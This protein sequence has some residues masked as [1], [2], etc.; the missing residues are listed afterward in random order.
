MSFHVV[1][2]FER[3]RSD[4]FVILLSIERAA[5]I[6]CSYASIVV[7]FL[8]SPE[9]VLSGGRPHRRSSVLAPVIEEVSDHRVMSFSGGLVNEN[10]SFADSDSLVDSAHEAVDSTVANASD[11][12]VAQALLKSSE[13]ESPVVDE[14]VEYGRVSLKLIDLTMETVFEQAHLQETT[15]GRILDD[16]YSKMHRQ[17]KQF[18]A[19]VARL[20]LESG[21]SVDLDTDGAAARARAERLVPPDEH[22]DRSR[23]DLRFPDTTDE[24]AFGTLP[25]ICLSIALPG[26]SMQCA[27]RKMRIG[28]SV[29]MIGHDPVTGWPIMGDKYQEQWRPQRKFEFEI[30]LEV[31]E[32]RLRFAVVV[33]GGPA[34]AAG[35]WASGLDSV[36]LHEPDLHWYILD[37]LCHVSDFCNRKCQ[38]EAEGSHPESV[39]NKNRMGISMGRPGSVQPKRYYWELDP[40]V[41]RREYPDLFRKSPKNLFQLAKL[42]PKLDELKVGVGNLIF[43][44]CIVVVWMS[45]Y[46]GILG[47]FCSWM[48]NTFLTSTCV[49][50]HEM[51]KTISFPARLQQDV[52]ALASLHRAAGDLGVGVRGRRRGLRRF[53]SYFA[54]RRGCR[55]ST[56]CTDTPAVGDERGGDE[57]EAGGGSRSG[58]GAELEHNM[59]LWV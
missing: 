21:F 35:Y 39:L 12:V 57:K 31:I 19:D 38:E 52:F 53:P 33:N 14:E 58:E 25:S 4:P 54:H 8:S 29:S 10:M 48:E 59:R 7:R 41:E 11:S 36:N 40:E 15:V 18:L 45:R 32:H 24:R 44:A 3:L 50:Q 5:F 51:K 55:T 28:A 42:I 17:R 56:S 2:S 9:V 16:L 37:D 43:F 49:E 20:C 1:L 6:M 34:P 30:R 27:F 13:V 26:M 46:G 47:K 23:Y 22:D